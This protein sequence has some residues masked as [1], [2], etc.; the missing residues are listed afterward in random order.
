M[1]IKQYQINYFHL[2]VQH[3]FSEMIVMIDIYLENGYRISKANYV[4]ETLERM[5]FKKV[6]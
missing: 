2:F 3:P 1:L 6:L 5:Q 4:R